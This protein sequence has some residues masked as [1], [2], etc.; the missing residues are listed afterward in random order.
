[1]KC[2]LE[3]CPGEYRETHIAQVFTRN[4]ESIV[5][6]GIPAKVC[7]V[8]GDTLLDWAAVERLW[9]TLDTAQQPRKY[10]PVY[11]FSGV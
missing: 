8:C 11:A 9:T 10:A 1:M 2:S 4:G 6:E 5:I 7:D 3:Q